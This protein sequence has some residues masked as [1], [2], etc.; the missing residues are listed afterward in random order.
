[1]ISSEALKITTRRR[2]RGTRLVIAALV[3]Q[4]ALT[5]WLSALAPPSRHV[6]AY[7]DPG[8]GALIV[9]VVVSLVTGVLLSLKRVRDTVRRALGRSGQE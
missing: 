9:Q 1:M 2:R 4:S 6:E 5:L 3:L 7:I 8:S